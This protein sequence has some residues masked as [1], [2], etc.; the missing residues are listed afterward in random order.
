MESRLLDLTRRLL[1]ML[2]P[3][4]AGAC[5]LI[6]SSIQAYAGPQTV[7]ENARQKAMNLP[8]AFEY[9]RPSVVQMVLSL[10]QPSGSAAAIFGGKLF[11]NLALG[12]GFFVNED[13]YVV[14]ARHV[15]KA[16]E[17][18]QIEARKRLFVGMA[19]PDMENLH[20]ISIRGNFTQLE[21]DIVDEDARHDLILLKLKRNPF[22]GETGIFMQ[23]GDKKIDWL[24]KAA[25]L[26]PDRPRDGEAVAV[27]GYPL[28]STV[29]VTTSGNLASSWSY[30]IQE[31]Q[32]PSAPAWFRMPDVADS[33]LADVRVNGGNSG[34]PVYSV[35]SSR[36]IGVCVSFHTAPVQYGN[37]NQEPVTIG[38]RPLLYNSGL[39]DVVPIRYVIDMLKKHNLKWVE[40]GR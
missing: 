25:I 32:V 16:F 22:K 12:T 2:K 26:S 15:V 6:L 37:G 20:G 31:I 4:A 13:G 40:A 21:F 23:A 10:D 19:G 5:L 28:S 30:E 36:V 3:F 7:K 17:N 14:T 24:H 1:P 8:G 35:E 34:G 18:L 11:L 33:Y 39:S 38:G 9:L 29:L 27:S